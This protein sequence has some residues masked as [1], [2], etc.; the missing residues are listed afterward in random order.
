MELWICT[1]TSSDWLC[2]A[3]FYSCPCMLQWGYHLLKTQRGEVDADLNDLRVVELAGLCHDL[4]HGPC[5]C[6]L[7]GGAPGLGAH[8]VARDPGAELDGRPSDPSSHAGCLMLP[9][10][11][12]SQPRV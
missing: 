10:A 1:A 11:G 3:G 7:A 2:C 9:D 4:G 5:R 12:F 6:V 8:G